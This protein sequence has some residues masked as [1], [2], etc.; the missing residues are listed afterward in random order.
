MDKFHSIVEAS[1]SASVTIGGYKF[2]RVKGDTIFAHGFELLVDMTTFQFYSVKGSKKNRVEVFLHCAD[3][4]DLLFFRKVF[5]SN[6]FESIDNPTELYKDF[7]EK[8][9][10]LI[11]SDD[12]DY[13]VLSDLAHLIKYYS[14]YW[15]DFLNRLLHRGIPTTKF[16]IDM[17]L[18][19]LRTKGVKVWQGKRISYF[20]YPSIGTE[21][22]A[23]GND[24]YVRDDGTLVVITKVLKELVKENSGNTPNSSSQK[25]AK[26]SPVFAELINR[27][28]ELVNEFG[29]IFII[30]KDKR[31]I[32]VDRDMK[33]GYYIDRAGYTFYFNNPN[34]R[35]IINTLLENK[36][37]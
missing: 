27:G 18:E 24:I 12:D 23:L 8:L 29:N 33:K 36:H 16:K 6:G 34:H 9:N 30:T 4:K 26:L 21:V 15:K 31:K 13:F 35:E 17:V 20:D 10:K 2:I 7:D 19:R 28:I 32:R 14:F 25:I 1:L 3:Q 5:L 11:G 37:A 22:I